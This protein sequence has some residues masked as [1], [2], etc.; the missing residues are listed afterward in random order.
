MVYYAIATY[1]GRT[2]R[3]FGVPGMRW[4]HRKS[5]EKAY[6]RDVRKLAKM[7]EKIGK[8]ELKSKKL[9]Y[10]AAKIQARGNYK[11]GFKKDAKSK[12][13][14][15]KAEKMRAKVSKKLAKME[16]KYKD[17]SVSQLNSA[18]VETAKKLATRYLR[19]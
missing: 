16:K 1:D 10:K 17:V 12:K 14:A 4:G 3:H 19:G 11:K 8:K 9:A 6:A 5:P 15:F 7:D 2:L 18:D 13:I